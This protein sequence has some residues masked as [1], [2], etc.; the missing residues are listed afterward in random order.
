MSAA[1]AAAAAAAD[2]P[3][4]RLV[5]ITTSQ[6]AN[7]IDVDLSGIDLTPYHELTLY[8]RGAVNTK[9]PELYLR[10]NNLTFY[11]YDGTSSINFLCGGWLLPYSTSEVS[12]VRMG[13]LLEGYVTGL[14]SVC[15]YRGSYNTTS[16]DGYKAFQDHVGSDNKLYQAAIRAGELRTINLF[17]T[18][19][20]T[21]VSIPAG[22]R[23]QLYGVK[24]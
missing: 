23:I 14:P 6:A 8:F 2:C 20:S 24:A 12:A 7:Q 19:S 5:S 3:L 10:V 11:S 16:S 17:A 15:A 9:G 21:P 22:S 13:L 4:Q 1:Q 18:N